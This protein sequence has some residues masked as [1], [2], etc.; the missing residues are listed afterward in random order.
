MKTL[1]ELYKEQHEANLV[2]LKINEQIRARKSEIVVQCESS[3]IGDG[4][5][6]GHK[7]KDLVYIQ[8]YWYTPPRGCTGGDYWNMGEGR[9]TCPTCGCINRLYNRPDI[10][11]KKP[12]F[13]EVVKYYK[14]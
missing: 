3:S 11:E 10:E 7:I 6:Q 8:T 4:C 14:N 13:K 12:M 2:S 9:F 5:G 1:T